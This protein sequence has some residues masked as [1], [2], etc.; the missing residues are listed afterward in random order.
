MTN[1]MNQNKEEGGKDK[2]HHLCIQALCITFTFYPYFN[3]II[4]L[5]FLKD[6]TFT[7]NIRTERLNTYR[8]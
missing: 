7:A 3:H 1:V 5:H 6:L 4:E 8:N 2:T